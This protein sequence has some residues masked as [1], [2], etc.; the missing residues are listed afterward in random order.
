MSTI[1]TSGFSRSMAAQRASPS[2]QT[3]N[4]WTR[5]LVERTAVM[6]SRTRYESSAATTRS[7]TVPVAGRVIGYP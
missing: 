5:S 3:S 1:A 4:S 6:A 7:G 2:E